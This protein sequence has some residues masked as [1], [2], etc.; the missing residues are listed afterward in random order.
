MVIGKVEAPNEGKVFDM[1]EQMPQFPGGT[2]KLNEYLSTHVQYPEEA[3]EKEYRD[4]WS[5]HSW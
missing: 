3:Q 5:W 4:V 1:V 2:E